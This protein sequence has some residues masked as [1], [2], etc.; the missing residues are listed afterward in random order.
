MKLILPLFFLLLQFYSHQL[1]AQDVSDTASKAALNIYLNCNFCYESFVKTE[2][3]WVNYMRD[4]HDAD[5]DLLISTQSTGSEGTEYTLTFTGQK[6]FSGMNDTLKYI[7]PSTNTED[8]SRKGLVQSIKLGLVR[9]VARTSYA[10]QIQISANGQA[11]GETIHSANDKWKSWVF[12]IR[13]NASLNGEKSTS[14][15]NYSGS[16]SA[17]KTTEKI[18]IDFSLYQNY[19]ENRF[20]FYDDEIKSFSRSRSLSASVIPSIN[21]HWSWGGFAITG[22]S[23]YNNKKFYAS[24]SPAV[25]YNIYPYKESTRRQLT[26]SYYLS[27]NHFSYNDTTIYN[28]IE[29][30]IFDHRLSLS[31]SVTQP[32]GS[33]SFSV[34][35]SNYLYDFSKNRISLFTYGDFR[36]F[37]G[38]SFNLFG[39][40]DLIHDQIALPKGGA[41]EEEVL[42][43]R[44]EL[45]TSY[46]YYVYIGITYRFGSIYNNIV[47]PRMNAGGGSY[48]FSF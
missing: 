44:K 11:A 35:A 38:L 6:K 33:A 45:E 41:S 43:R 7:T 13:G 39:S 34:Q 22:S 21:E 18:K 3:K 8:E 27:I 37:K 29:E 9:Y 40:Y 23:T 28:K 24:I 12:N 4:R 30:D 5:V 46:R 17:N 10:S 2:I 19:G 36:I 47:N 14:S 32:W 26:L 42:L 1:F 31:L 48:S 15:Q 16:L 20:T 25:E